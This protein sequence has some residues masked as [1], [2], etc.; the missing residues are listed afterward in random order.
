MVCFYSKNK[1]IC[2]SPIYSVPLHVFVNIAYA[3]PIQRSI[4]QFAS[5]FTTILSLDW[6]TA[7]IPAGK[8]PAL[9]VN[10]ADLT[11]IG[12]L[13]LAVLGLFLFYALNKSR[14]SGQTEQG[15]GAA[16]T[17]TTVSDRGEGRS[18]DRQDD[19][20]IVGAGVA[21]AALAHTLGKVLIFLSSI[22]FVFVLEF[23]FPGFVLVFLCCMYLAW[24]RFIN[25]SAFADNDLGIHFKYVYV[26]KMKSIF[27]F[28]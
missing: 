28:F 15:T 23:F 18:K 27:K 17:A 10:M 12:S 8:L 25:F 22:C 1:T 11:F 7:T 14:K 4:H 6:R 3:K 16:S 19:V 21:G 26:L 24:S 2:L 13:L 5:S 20:I 9:P